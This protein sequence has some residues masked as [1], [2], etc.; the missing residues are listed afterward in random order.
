MPSGRDDAGSSRRG[1][2]DVS[3]LKVPHFLSF[4]SVGSHRREV[5]RVVVFWVVG[6]GGKETQPE[7][8][9]VISFLAQPGARR[10]APAQSFDPYL[11]EK[12]RTILLLLRK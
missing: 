6:V 7:P 4:L 5:E 2:Y 8:F 9:R 1:T 3:N 12:A 11:S 10:G